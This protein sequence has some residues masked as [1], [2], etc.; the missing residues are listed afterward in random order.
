[1]RRLAKTYL[2]L[3]LIFLF[4]ITSLPAFAG[5]GDGSG[6]GSDNPLSLVSSYPS[7]GQKNI[8]QM[9]N[10]K[11]TFS[12]NVI[13]MSV[14]DNNKKYFSI[15]ADDG[16]TVPIEVIMADDQIEPEKKRDVWLKPLNK[17]KPGTSYK[18]VINPE[19]TSKSGVALG[20]QVT[21]SFATSGQKDEPSNQHN[22][23]A[24]SNTVNPSGAPTANKTVAHQSQIKDNRNPG[25]NASDISGSTAES[26]S[27]LD[28]EQRQELTNKKQDNK[29]GKKQDIPIKL[30]LPFVLAIIALVSYVVLRRKGKK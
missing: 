8:D 4:L 22:A 3:M 6:G 13:N 7:D 10:I 24:N 16:S 2:F 20:K 17:L 19:L 12:K 9:V 23:V 25:N 1:M 27:K 14:R 21:V 11:L 5:N 30:W 29:D 28:N 15:L 26:N 18:V